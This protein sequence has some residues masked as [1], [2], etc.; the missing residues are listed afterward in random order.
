MSCNFLQLVKVLILYFNARSG[1][2]DQIFE[3]VSGTAMQM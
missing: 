1:T 3:P 2:A